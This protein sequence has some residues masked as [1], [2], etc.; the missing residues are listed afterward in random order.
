LPVICRSS[1]IISTDKTKAKTATHVIND[2]FTNLQEEKGRNL[3]EAISKIEKWLE[4]K[5]GAGS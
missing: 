4:V 1:F 2:F 3:L 5:D